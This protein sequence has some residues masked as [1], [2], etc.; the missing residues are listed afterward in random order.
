[1]ILVGSQ[2]FF[3]NIEGFIPKDVDYIELVDN[4]SEFKYFCQITGKNK[5]IFRWKRMNVNEFINIHLKFN[6]PMSVGKFL[7]PEFAKEINL[8]ITDLKKLTPLIEKLD[9]KHLYEK[10][11][12]NS[13]IENNGFYLTNEQLME[14]YNEYK[15]YR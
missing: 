3:N 9:D 13:Y 6:I 14:S 7:V 1:M 10:I 11:I 2:S 8:T 15:K 4:P 12:F 5:C